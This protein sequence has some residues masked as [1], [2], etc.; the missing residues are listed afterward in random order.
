MVLTLT[1]TFGGTYGNNLVL[2]SVVTERSPNNVTNTSI[3]NVSIYLDTNSYVTASA[4]GSLLKIN[5]GSA[6]GLVQRSVSFNV[7]PNTSTLI[8]AEDFTVTHDED[9]SKSFQYTAELQYNVTGYTFSAHTGVMNLTTLARA[10]TVSASDTNFGSSMPITI[11]RK[12]SSYTH[13]LIYSIGSSSGIIA[14]NVDTSYS[15]TVPNELMNLIPNNTSVSAY[16][17]ADTYSGSTKIGSN[18]IQVTLTIPSNV[19]PIAGITSLSE[20]TSSLSKISTSTTYVQTLSKV[21]AVVSG[22]SGVYGSTIASYKI[23]IVGQNMTLTANNSTFGTFSNSGDFTVRTTVTDS[24]GRTSASFTTDITVIPYSMPTGDFTAWRDGSTN[25][26]VV[27]NRNARVSPLIV[28]GVQKNKLQIQFSYAPRNG[29]TFV[30]STG[31][32]NETLTATYELINSQ[33]S[34][35]ETFSTTS[36]YDI[37]MTVSDNFFTDIKVLKTVGTET[38]PFVVKDDRLGLGKIPDIENAVDSDWLYYYKG[39]EIQNH[40][41][42]QANGNSINNYYSDLNDDIQTGFYQKA[43]TAPNLPSGAQYGFLRVVGSELDQVSQIYH[44]RDG[45]MRT[46]TRVKTNGVW[47]GWK[48]LVTSDNGMLVDTGWV[49]LSGGASYRRQGNLVYVKFNV[50]PTNTSAI[51]LGTL[52]SSLVPME[53]FF[54]APAHAAVN[55][56]NGMMQLDT[57]GGLTLFPNRAIQYHGQ[58]SW[59]L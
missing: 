10:S 31:N 54:V 2:R 36:S 50:T 58:I 3:V 29:T 40:K 47:K 39:N 52:P 20:T 6:G 26:R 38:F 17:I 46:F 16:I 12:S 15:W 1:S 9:G 5:L 35:V 59:C 23:E 18:S 41:L 22:A 45:Q 24:R 7:T 55:D 27:V 8:H 37:V 28:G 56:A 14:K 4:G 11:D 13:T 44:E 48:Q 51:F 33:A 57:S 19:I 21:K 34:L 32:A 43:N 30:N 49:T 42:T 25:T 53:M